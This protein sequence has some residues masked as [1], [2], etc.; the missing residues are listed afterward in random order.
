MS[1]PDVSGVKIRQYQI[2]IRLA[3]SIGDDD[4]DDSKY[5]QAIY[6][7]RVKFFGKEYTDREWGME[8]FSKGS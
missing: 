6:D 4:D 7:E 5:V 1:N 8:P 3:Q 2:L